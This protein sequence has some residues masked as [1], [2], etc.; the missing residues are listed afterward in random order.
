MCDPI[1]TNVVHTPEN[2][3]WWEGMG[4]DPPTHGIDWKGN[5]WT[6]ESGEKGAHPNSRLPRPLPEKL[7]G[8]R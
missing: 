2:T 3:V 5:P 1:F 6:P 7:I 4:F 8:P